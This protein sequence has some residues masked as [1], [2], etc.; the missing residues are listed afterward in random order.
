MGSRQ[1]AFHVSAGPA[2]VAERC[3]AVTGL[4]AGAL[5]DNHSTEAANGICRHEAAS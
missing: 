3:S 5:Y 1:I 2:S 4:T